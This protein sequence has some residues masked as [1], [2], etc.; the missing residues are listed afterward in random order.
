M[1]KFYLV[2]AACAALSMN[3]LAQDVQSATLTV[4]DYDG[5]TSMVEGSYFDVAPTSFYVAHTGSQMLYTAEDLA[6]FA[7]KEE[8]K[9]TKLTYRFYNEA[10]DDITRD[11]KLYLQE[12]DATAVE[13]IDG[14]KQFFDFDASAPVLEFEGYYEL[15]DFYGDDGEMEF[16]LANAPFE[17]T[18]GK[19]LLVTVIFDAQEDD[20]CTDGTYVQFYSSGLRNRAMTYTNN[21]VSFVDYTETEDFPKATATLGCGTSI[22]L[23]VTKID[24][25]YVDPIDTGIDE[26]KTATAT[27]GAYYNLMGQKLNGNNLPAGIYIHNGKKYIAK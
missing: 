8:V 14:V 1:K 11:V 3:A 4:G 24:Y 26:V 15:L 13:V 7:D 25:T 18:P 22:E 6:D 9:V 16:D 21:T 2:F 19:G 20:N 12:V 27:D 17:V 23:P 5:A 10:F